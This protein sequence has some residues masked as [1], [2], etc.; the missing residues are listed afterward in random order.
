MVRAARLPQ[1]WEEEAGAAAEAAQHRAHEA[2]EAERRAA[3]HRA[4]VDRSAR[5]LA[6]DRAELQVPH[7]PPA[8][9]SCFA[10]D[11]DPIPHC[12]GTAI[13]VHLP[14]TLPRDAGAILLFSCWS[15][16]QFIF[17]PG[18]HQIPVH[19]VYDH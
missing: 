12:L 4:E 14:R 13:S 17:M 8:P 5:A 9:E 15:G 1:K 10:P 16:R 6:A 7:V 11:V 19:F 18:H 2:G 3:A